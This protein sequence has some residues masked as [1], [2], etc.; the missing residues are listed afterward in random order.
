MARYLSKRTTDPINESVAEVVLPS[1]YEVMEFPEQ[2]DYKV[3]EWFEIVNNVQDKFSS[4]DGERVM[5]YVKRP[6]DKDMLDE[7][8]YYVP[9]MVTAVLDDDDG[10]DEK[11][12][13]S[14]IFPESRAILSSTFLKPGLSGAIFLLSFRLILDGVTVVVGDLT[15]HAM[16]IY[17]PD[18]YLTQNFQTTEILGTSRVGS[19]KDSQKAGPA[20]REK[21]Q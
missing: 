18:C 5:Y 8:W 12:T 9:V 6:D 17:F 7:S 10:K 3:G 11:I 21:V 2:I 14:S 19:N 20:R 13:K 15:C 1:E 4:A 16:S